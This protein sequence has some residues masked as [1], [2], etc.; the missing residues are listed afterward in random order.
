M[1]NSAVR[2]PIAF[3]GVRFV[4]YHVAYCTVPVPNSAV[5]YPIAYNGVR[6]VLYHI[7]YC[8]HNILYP[9]AYCT[10]RYTKLIVRRGVP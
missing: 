5:R 10:A 2:Y 3:N 9:I 8:N 1:P 6:I 7:A 4:L